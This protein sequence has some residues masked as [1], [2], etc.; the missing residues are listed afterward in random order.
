MNELNKLIADSI[1]LYKIEVGNDRLKLDTN[2][3][4]QITFRR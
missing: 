3:N 4:N 1:F 2:I